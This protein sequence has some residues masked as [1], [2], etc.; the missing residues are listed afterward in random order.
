MNR[1]A[2]ISDSLAALAAAACPA[3]A[4]AT[5]WVEIEPGL[6]VSTNTFPSDCELSV[7]FMEEFARRVACSFGM[8]A[9]FLC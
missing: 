3:I 4:G 2:F 5:T 7:D 6:L 1:R 9:E 8:S